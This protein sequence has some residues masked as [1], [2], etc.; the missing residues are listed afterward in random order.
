MDQHE[1]HEDDFLYGKNVTCPLCNTATSTLMVKR[2]ALRL[3]S[4]DSDS[5][6]YYKYINPLFYDVCQCTHCGYA[7]LQSFFDHEIKPQ[8]KAILME[9]VASR[10]NPRNF[11]NLYDVKTALSHYKIALY[12]TKLRNADRIEPTLLYLKM[13]WIYR[14]QDNK[15]MECKCLTQA[16]EGFKYLYEVGDFPVAGMDECSL[17]YMIADL[18]NRINDY[19]QSLLWLGMV[20]NNNQAKSALKDKARDL[21]YLI[22]HESKQLTA[23]AV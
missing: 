19:K 20:L 12:C 23:A 22:S 4:K 1:Y 3:V 5:M 16:V 11:P 17:I 14:L 21:K 9:K 8:D 13:G 7:A 15:E 2:S 6:P 18:S 10:W